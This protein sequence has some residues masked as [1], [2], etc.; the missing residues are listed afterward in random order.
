MSNNIDRLN[1]KARELH[2]PGNVEKYKG[3]YAIT[4]EDKPEYLGQH[5]D[6]AVRHLE[7]LAKVYEDN[8]FATLGAERYDEYNDGHSPEKIE[9]EWRQWWEK[10][11]A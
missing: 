1:D 10:Q 5:F 7:M 9:D 11:S 3:C 2:I 8:H 6:E 4:I